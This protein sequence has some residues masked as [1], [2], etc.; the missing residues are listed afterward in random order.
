MIS[1][2]DDETE[3]GGN[4]AEV[5]LARVFRNPRLAKDAGDMR[6]LHVGADADVAVHAV[7]HPANCEQPRMTRGDIVGETRFF[8][9]RVRREPAAAVRPPLP[10]LPRPESITAGDLERGDG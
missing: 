1:P 3:P 6:K 9:I 4:P 2:A 5:R 10:Q 7:F 8:L